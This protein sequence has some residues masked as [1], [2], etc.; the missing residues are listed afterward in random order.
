MSDKLNHMFVVHAV[1]ETLTS[2]LFP[3]NYYLKTN[4]YDI[5]FAPFK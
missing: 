4:I 5:C 2:P 1:F 3:V